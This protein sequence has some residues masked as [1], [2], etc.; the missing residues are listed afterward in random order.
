ALV[1]DKTIDSYKW[2]LRYTKKAIRA[3]PLV[4]VTDANPVIDMEGYNN[5]IKCELH[6]N[7]SLYNLVKTLDS[8]L[9]KEAEWNRFFEYQTL[10]LCIRL[11]LVGTEETF[12][13][14]NK[15]NKALINEIDNN[16]NQAMLTVANLLV[17]KH[18]SRPK[19]K[20]YKAAIEKT[21]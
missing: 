10:S 1:F 8:R 11:I 6:S 16:I 12:L 2:I 7:S 14:R 20:R 17:T 21:H 19:T 5:I 3:E 9:E 4:F 15:E 18:K 13:E